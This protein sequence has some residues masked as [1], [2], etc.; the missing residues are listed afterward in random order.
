MKP[1]IFPTNFQITIHTSISEIF[2]GSKL[3]YSWTRFCSSPP[4]LPLPL[5]ALLLPARNATPQPPDS[6]SDIYNFHLSS[7]TF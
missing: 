3:K 7:F 6:W 5:L 2:V 4:P 1:K